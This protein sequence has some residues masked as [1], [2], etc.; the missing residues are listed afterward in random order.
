M[1]T[2]PYGRQHRAILQEI[3]C[4]AMHERG[5]VTEFSNSVLSELHR[6]KQPRSRGRSPVKGQ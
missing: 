3:A 2:D 5:L 6:A 4:E 1:A